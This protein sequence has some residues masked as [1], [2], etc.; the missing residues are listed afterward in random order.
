M[1]FGWISFSKDMYSQVIENIQKSKLEISNYLYVPIVYAFILVGFF[2]ICMTFVQHSIQKYKDINSNIVAFIAGGL[3]G[4][5][6]V[7]VHHFT[8]LILYKNY[9]LY[10][11]ILDLLWQ[12]ALYGTAS[13]VYSNL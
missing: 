10:I 2:L 9:S 3:Y 4:F 8:S 12:F 1:D 6:V 5:I 7:G 11:A 13:V